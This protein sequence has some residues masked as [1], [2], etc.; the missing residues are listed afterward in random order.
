M[1]GFVRARQFVH[2]SPLAVRSG[3]AE[4]KWKM[5]KNRNKN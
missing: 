2:L 5:E 4:N 1:G 3:E